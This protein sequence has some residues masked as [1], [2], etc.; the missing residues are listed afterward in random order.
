MP[1]MRLRELRRLLGLVLGRRLPDAHLLHHRGG[2]VRDPP[3]RQAE[4]QQEAQPPAGVDG[5]G[6]NVRSRGAGAPARG[7]DRDGD[8]RQ[9][10]PEAEALRQLRLEL[11]AAVGVRQ[12]DRRRDLGPPAGGAPEADRSKRIGEEAS[13]RG[14]KQ[15]EKR[16]RRSGAREAAAAAARRRRRQIDRR[17]G[18]GRGTE[19]LLLRSVRRVDRREARQE[20]R[21]E[22]AEE[23]PEPIHEAQGLA[24]DTEPG[25]GTAEERAEAAEIG[26]AG[27]REGEPGQAPDRREGHDPPRMTARTQTRTHTA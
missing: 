19:G 11:P 24:Q 10:P 16:R 23:G 4:Q 20:D 8:P 7:D 17:G 22:G 1:T 6:R 26:A 3:G 2:A 5:R 21:Q 14:D 27:K 15:P 25:D 13:R 18:A 12:A 9:H